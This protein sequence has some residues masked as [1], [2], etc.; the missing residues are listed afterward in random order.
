[1]GSETSVWLILYGSVVFKWFKSKFR[2]GI[3]W[4]KFSGFDGQHGVVMGN[5]AYTDLKI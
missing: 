2:N 4:V 5:S 1:M 3:I